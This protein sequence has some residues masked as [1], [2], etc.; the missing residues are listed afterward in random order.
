MTTPWTLNRWSSPSDPLLFGGELQPAPLSIDALVRAIK[1]VSDS[2]AN[3]LAFVIAHA[4][5]SDGRSLGTAIRAMNRA[6]IEP[7]LCL[8][9][10]RWALE[11][12]D[13][14]LVDTDRVGVLLD[15]VGPET[16]LS[17]L[18]GYAIEAIR[19]R[20]DFVA[21]AA[22]SLQ[23]G[24]VLEAMLQLAGDLG[25]KTIGPCI[26]PA[27]GA[28]ST[29]SQFDYVPSSVLPVTKRPPLARDRRRETSLRPA[30]DQRVR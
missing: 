17:V 13:M 21:V 6:S 8:A 19:F 11:A 24:L 5:F 10:D 30:S 18:A 20:A 22:Q 25:L 16:P 29:S 15:D 4:A 2:D 1:H 26:L 3:G 12:I 28:A 14:R 7:R 23:L 9:V 27:E